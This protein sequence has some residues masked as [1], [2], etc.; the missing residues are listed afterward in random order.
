MLACLNIARAIGRRRVEAEALATLGTVALGLHGPAPALELLHQALRLGREIGYRRA[1]VNAHLGLAG[2]YRVANRPQEA[3]SHARLGEQLARAAQHHL[4][5]RQ[6]RA[7]L[8][9]AEPES[10]LRPAC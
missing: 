10:L 8:G 1:E 4:L 9:D 6:A 2:A 5:A 3:A 7:L